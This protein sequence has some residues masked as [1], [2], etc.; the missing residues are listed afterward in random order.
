LCDVAKISGFSYTNLIIINIF[1]TGDMKST[2]IFTNIN[3]IL[4]IEST[5][6]SKIFLWDE[7]FIC[8]DSTEYAVYPEWE[9]NKKPKKI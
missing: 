8:F 5:R 1:K 7:W 3:T 2:L 9:Y 4:T 6:R